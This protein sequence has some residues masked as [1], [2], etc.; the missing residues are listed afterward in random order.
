MLAKYNLKAMFD[1]KNPYANTNVKFFLYV[2]S[3]EDCDQIK[4]G[5]YK[6]QLKNKNNKPNNSGEIVIP[7]EYPEEYIDYLNNIEDF[8]DND[9]CPQDTD[10]QE[11]GIIDSSVRDNSVWNPNRYNKQTLEIKKA[12][13]KEKTVLLSSVAT[14]IK[15][16][17][18]G[19]ENYTKHCLSV[20]NWNYP[21]NYDKLKEGRETNCPLQKGD[22][23]FISK[24]KMFLLYE[25]PPCPIHASMMAYII[26]PTNISPEYLYL[27]LKSETAQVVLQSIQVGSVLPKI[28]LEDIKN[29]PVILPREDV[30]N[31]K[32]IFYTQNFSVKNMNDYNHILLQLAGSKND[33]CVE[34]ILTQELFLFGNG[35]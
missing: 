29:F 8:I 27:Y 9:V 1:I 5:I 10:S 28:K 20:S 14:I 22:I 6:K 2:F 24:D 19:K 21:I 12:L 11:F 3:K 32:K 33:E 15:P 7:N 16:K 26:R 4:Y 25:T 34:G 35:A 31:Y 18:I 17:Y 23:I 13:R 30:E